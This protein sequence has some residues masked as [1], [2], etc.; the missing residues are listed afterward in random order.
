MYDNGQGL[1]KN[2]AEAVRWYRLAAD[3]GYAMAQSNLG[4]MYANGRG[5]PENDVEA[6]KWW[7][8]AA[9]QGNA[10]AF[11]NRGN[12]YNDE[13]DYARAIADYDQAIGLQPNNAE[14]LNSRCWAR[15]VW[16]QQLDQ[17]LSDCDASL[18]IANEP[19]TLD[20]RGLVH[21]RRSEFQAAF[22][23]YDAAVRANLIGSL[24]GRGIARLRLGQIAEGQAD[25]VAATGRDANIAAR[26]ATY[27]VTP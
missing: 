25:I 18:R 17:A 20:S 8:L 22:A 3:Q 5:V 16:G 4:V 1:A 23:D 15:A 21:L 19:N 26:F 11:I 6:Y 24:Y 14:W 2:D 27:G 9:A 7:S 12:A 10:D 13:R